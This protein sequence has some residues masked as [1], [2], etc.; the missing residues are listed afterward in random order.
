MDAPLPEPDIVSCYFDAGFQPHL[1][2][3]CLE[4]KDSAETCRPRRWSLPMGVSITAP[5]P[6]RF[7][8]DIQRQDINDYAVR[9][10]WNQT[11]LGWPSLSRSQLLESSLFHLL[12]A[13]GTDLHYLLDQPVV[14]GEPARPR[15]K[16]G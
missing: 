9:M 1:L 2:A 8:I 11:H 12:A 6:M 10:L 5:A 3:M 14:V 13:M 15:L 7:G 4:W 16:V